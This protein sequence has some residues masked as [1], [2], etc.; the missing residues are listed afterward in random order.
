MYIK[1]LRGKLLHA[2]RKNK[3]VI[4]IEK[5]FVVED[6]MVICTATIKIFGDTYL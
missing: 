6:I 1:I 5:T 4:A 2:L 3:L